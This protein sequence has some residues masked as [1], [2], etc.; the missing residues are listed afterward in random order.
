MNNSVFS[1]AMNNI[2]NGKGIKLVTNRESY[3]K[4]LMKPSFK[5][6]ICFRSNLMEFEMGKTK[7]LMN[8][9]VYLGQAI[10]DLR[11]LVMYEFPYDYMI[12]KYTRGASK[13]YRENVKPCYMDTDSL[14][15]HIKNEDFYSDIAEDVKAKFDRSGFREPG[16]LPMALVFCMGFVFC[17]I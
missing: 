9:P 6:A 1:E 5:S 17:C 13:T 8:K 7:V 4:T 12:P 10:L 11:K 15:Y 16:P 14:V 3:L 2:R